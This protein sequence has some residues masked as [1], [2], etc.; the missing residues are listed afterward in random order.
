[1]ATVLAVLDQPTRQAVDTVSID[2]T[3][4]VSFTLR[5]GATVVWGV[6]RDNERKAAVLRI[7]L[8]QE[9][10]KY[11]VSAPNAPVTE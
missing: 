8:K 3:D 11:D 1:M 5:S 9:A 6:A 2:G 4:Q 10:K 7:L